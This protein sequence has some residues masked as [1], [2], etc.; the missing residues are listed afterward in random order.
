MR[1]IAIYTDGPASTRQRLV[2][3][4]LV[5][6]SRMDRLWNYAVHTHPSSGFR[7][8]KKQALLRGRVDTIGTEV[9]TYEP[10]RETRTGYQDVL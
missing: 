4:P 7:P 10:I 3:A 6:V 8:T 2:A 5:N 1:T 9:E